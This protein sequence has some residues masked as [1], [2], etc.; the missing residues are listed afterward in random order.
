MILDLRNSPVISFH[1]ECYST[2]YRAVK[3]VIWAETDIVY[4]VIFSIIIS[5]V[6]G[7]WVN[8][9]WKP[10][11]PRLDPSVCSVG[12][13]WNFKG[14]GPVLGTSGPWGCTLCVGRIGTYALPLPLSGLQLR[15]EWFCHIM[16]SPWGCAVL[17]LAAAGP[18]PPARGLPNCEPKQTFS[19]Q[20]WFVSRYLLKKLNTE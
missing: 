18:A 4:S 12:Q 2:W 11:C 8:V 15:S 14:Q 17:L 7:V 20:R 13:W 3:T 16:C 6:A 19:L 10:V 1:K 5:G 9:F